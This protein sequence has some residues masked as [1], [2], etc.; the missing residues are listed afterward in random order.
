MFDFLFMH[1]DRHICSLEILQSACVVEMQMTHD[2]SFDVF[3]IMACLLDLCRQLMLRKIFH[4]FEDVV[5]WRS[6]GSR[7]ILTG[8]RF[9]E[10]ESFRWVFNQYGY[11]DKFPSGNSGIFIRGK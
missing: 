1:I 9:E 10:N 6:P 3:D 5:Q 11:N 7:I 4:S 8:T 2:Y